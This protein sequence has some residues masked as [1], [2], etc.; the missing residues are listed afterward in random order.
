MGSVSTENLQLHLF[1]DASKDAYA[2][3]VFLRVDTGTQGR[4]QFIM[5]KSR[6]S[7]LAQARKITIPRLELPGCVIGARLVHG[8]VKA[9]SFSDI[10]LYCWSDSSTALAWIRRDDQWGTFVHNRT[11]R[12]KI[13]GIRIRLMSHHKGV[14]FR[15]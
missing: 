15:S 11:T 14:R 12:D 10:P 4:V 9:F 7:P 2:A 5:A 8:V 6:L 1:T 3:V 13:L